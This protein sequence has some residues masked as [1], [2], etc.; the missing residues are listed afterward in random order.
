M[1]LLLRFLLSLF[2]ILLN[3]HPYAHTRQESV[4]HA[5]LQI[6]VRAINVHNCDLPDNLLSFRSARSCPQNEDDK[7]VAPDEREDEDDKQSSFRDYAAVG[8]LVSNNWNVP[9]P[10]FDPIL[11]KKRL[12]AC[13]PFSFYTINRYIVFR[14]IRI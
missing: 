2:F 8:T 4:P 9:V 3:S 10:D 14:A 1:K 11:I 13:K 7:L 5:P 12:L 6:S